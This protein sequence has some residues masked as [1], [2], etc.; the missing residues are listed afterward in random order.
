MLSMKLNTL[1]K[2]IMSIDYLLVPPTLVMEETVAKMLQNNRSEVLV[3]DGAGSLKG[4]LTL[5]DVSQISQQVSD[6]QQKPISQFAH[7][8]VL[9]I[10]P[11]DQSSKAN[12]LMREKNIGVL[13]VLEDNKVIGVIRVLD[14]LDKIY[15][16]IDEEYQSL[17]LILDNLS[18]AVCVVDTAGVVVKWSKK[19]ERLYRVLETEIVGKNLEIFFPNAL[20]LKVLKD[21]KPIENIY[22]T[23]RKDAHMVISAIP[24]F[25]NDEFVGAVSTDRDV[26]EITKLTMELEVTKDR[27]EIL[28]EE[29]NKITDDRFSF[30]G[31]ILGRS[32]VLRDQIERAQRVAKTNTNVLITGESGTGKEVFARAIHNA[33]GRTGPFIAVN[34]SAVPENLFES[35]MFGYVEGAFTGALKKGKP[36]KFVLANKGTLFLDEIGDM[37]LYMQ[38]KL[39]RV[40]QE[41]QVVPVGSDSPTE[42]DVRIISATHRDLSSMVL[43]HLFRE[44]LFYR[45]NVVRIELPPLRERREDI[46][47][48]LNQFILEF[49][50]ENN[51]VIPKM[52]IEVLKIL[53]N[54]HWAGN[55]R[56]LKNTVQHL[57]VFSKNG[58][59]QPESIPKNIN[60]GAS[61]GHE[62]VYDLQRITELA[63]IE[64]INKVMKLT[65]NNKSQAAK[66]LNI[67][68]S[69]LYYKIKYYDLKE[70]F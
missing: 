52:D 5:T 41:R 46:P 13:P 48:L 45:L 7:R 22:H 24:L 2:D 33:S 47:A 23:P 15:S 56:E 9:T 34:C 30:G 39:L 57:V 61:K 67:P 38:A 4:I 31:M 42:I 43:E 70:L 65:E 26:T 3:T 1:V 36:G 63:E 25:V 16:K 44:D 14:I 68:R 59:I 27:L 28:Q 19:A 58:E 50:E 66:L 37:P 60:S 40:I 18:E 32:D 55:I 29:V 12:N 51:L 8:Q 69:T 62:E 6:W 10:S 35:E 54:Y 64:T 11:Y 17:S 53:M 49:C 21:R 20:L